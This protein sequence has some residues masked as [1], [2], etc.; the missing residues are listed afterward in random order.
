MTYRP[1]IGITMRLE[2]ATRRFYLGR[3]YSEA[4]IG[5]GA[6]PVHI[7]LVP[8]SEF[9]AG[10]LAGLDG[11]LLPGSDTDVD[12]LRFGEHPHPKLGTVVPEKDE[13]DL[14]VLNEAEDRGLPVFAICYGMQ[15]LNVHR[16]G[17]LVQDIDSQV[18]DA[19]KHQ[20]GLPLERRSHTV[21]IEPGSLLERALGV[22]ETTLHVNSHH[23]QA[24]GKIGKDL[25]ATAL[26][27]D[28]VIEAIEDTRNERFAFGAQWHPELDWRNDKLSRELFGEFV[29]TAME[30]RSKGFSS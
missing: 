19:I 13:T 22:G 21:Q 8:D 24:I 26:A 14:L 7:P 4:L 17:T 28:G 30:R 11:V 16:G 3:D 25:R 20:Q 10:L 12:P 18:P 15:V 9:I 27:G 1:L 23:H 5:S 6:R 29:K 2:L